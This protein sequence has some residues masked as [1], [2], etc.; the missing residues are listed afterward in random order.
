MGLVGVPAASTSGSASRPMESPTKATLGGAGSCACASVP[1]DPIVA[2]TSAALSPTTV[3][4]TRTPSLPSPLGR[5]RYR[6]RPGPPIRSSGM[7][8][9]VP[10]T[11]LEYDGVQMFDHLTDRE[12]EGWA[13]RL[14]G[15]RCELDA[16]EAGLLAEVERR[17]GV[18]P[19]GYRDTAAWLRNATGV[20]AAT[21]RSRVAVARTLAKLP[22][23]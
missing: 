21:A 9:L 14:H 19:S 8:D 23:V 1:G 4:R 15:Q 5:G 17:R 7:R 11:A 18:Q 20:A 13:Q 16:T 2:T 22:M 6:P 3:Q 12:L 10:V